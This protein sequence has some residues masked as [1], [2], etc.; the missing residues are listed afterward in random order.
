[1]THQKSNFANKLGYIYERPPDKPSELERL[2]KYFFKNEVKKLMSRTLAS[3][4]NIMTDQL[5]MRSQDHFPQKKDG[6]FE[7]GS[8]HPKHIFDEAVIQNNTYIFRIIMS[9]VPNADICFTKKPE[10]RP[11]WFPN[12]EGCTLLSVSVFYRNVFITKTLIQ[13]GYIPSF[14]IVGDHYFY[15]SYT[16]FPHNNVSR[17]N[18]IS[19]TGLY[20]FSGIVSSCPDAMRPTY[21]KFSSDINFLMDCNYTFTNNLVLD[22]LHNFLVMLDTN[23]LYRFLQIIDKRSFTV[24]TW[25][26]LIENILHERYHRHI[27]FRSTTKQII[28]IL[29]TIDDAKMKK[30]ASMIFEDKTKIPSKIVLRYLTSTQTKKSLKDE[31]KNNLLKKILKPTSIAMQIFAATAY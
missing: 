29:F 28:N 23:V 11:Y 22:N 12:F 19:E 14:E 24:D 1:M 18:F 26:N 25:I 7:V 9:E 10:S 16:N 20:N 2:R 3:G 30:C 21:K 8:H 31:I 13:K 27:F 5:V 15:N 17:I 6:Y 4:S